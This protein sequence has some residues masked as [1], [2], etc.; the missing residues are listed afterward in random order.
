VVQ[1]RDYSAFAGIYRNNGRVLSEST[2][3]SLKQPCSLWALLTST[4][5]NIRSQSVMSCDGQ[6]QVTPVNEGCLEIGWSSNDG[7]QHTT[8]VEVE[9]STDLAAWLFSSRWKFPI[10]AI[11][12]QRV[13]MYLSEDG[14][15]V[16]VDDYQLAS[17]VHAVRNSRVLIFDRLE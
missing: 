17:V 6:V 4:S 7:V 11:G 13:S 15:L 10:I 3:L 16:V 14:S 5:A 1:A 9:Y 12:S 2:W 8:R